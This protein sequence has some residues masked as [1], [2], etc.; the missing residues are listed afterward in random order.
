[1]IISIVYKREINDEPGGYLYRVIQTSYVPPDG[2]EFHDKYGESYIFENYIYYE[3][4]GSF[5][6]M[7]DSLDLSEISQYLTK[8]WLHYTPPEE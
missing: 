4:E 3:E 6:I 1:M 7:L 8:G 2:L 5:I